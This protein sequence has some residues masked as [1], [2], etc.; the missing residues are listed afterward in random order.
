MFGSVVSD[1]ASSASS[2]ISGESHSLHDNHHISLSET[3][4]TEPHSSGLTTYKSTSTPGYTSQGQSRISQL[5]PVQSPI[6][7]SDSDNPFSPDSYPGTPPT[8][9][10]PIH[11]TT[12]NMWSHPGPL[13]VSS[14]L[15]KDRIGLKEKGTEKS[16]TVDQNSSN[17]IKS[18]REKRILAMRTGNL[19]HL[20]QALP[21]VTHSNC[22]TSLT[23][24]DMKGPANTTPIAVFGKTDLT[25]HDRKQLDN[26]KNSEE[27]DHGKI[28][29][30]F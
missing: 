20:T 29:T 14:P 1:S 2:Q 11:G 3:Q 9:Q 10:Q 12:T 30:L 7:V 16:T 8:G 15:V 5:F 22:D 17:E 25:K 21:S 4:H 18:E 26:N 27:Q 13:K 24:T 6:I 28:I 19:Q 23:I